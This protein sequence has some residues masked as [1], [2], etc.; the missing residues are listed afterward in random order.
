M[1]SEANLEQIRAY[2][3]DLVT[4]ATGDPAVRKA[5]ATVPRERFLGPGP[6]KVF[7]WAD[8]Q[9]VTTPSDDPV[10]IYQNVLIGLKPEEGVNNGDPSLHARML[11]ALNLSP[12]ETVLHLGCGTGYYTALIAE[13]VGEDGSVLAIDI[14]PGLAELARTN[15]SPWQH[16][17]VDCRSATDG[18]LPAADAI[19]V[20]AGT[21]M[22]VRHWVEALNPGGRLLFPLLG[23][24]G[25]GANLLVTNTGPGY[26]A[27]FVNRAAF[28]ACVGAQSAED[29][30]VL[31]KAFRSGGWD[32]VCSLHLDTPPD[33]TCWVAGQGWWLSTA[34]MH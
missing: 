18:A 3:A 15:L 26:A 30:H 10:F 12:G 21:N 14:D 25:W 6:W 20:N 1:R 28:I 23:D 7:V 2:Y 4:A 9:Y 29:G 5:F 13:L 17:T 19:Y 32:T 31:D 11:S 33:D 16:V 34:A 8:G 27:R 22:V 24:S